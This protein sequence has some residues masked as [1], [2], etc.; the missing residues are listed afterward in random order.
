[1]KTRQQC[2][3]ILATSALLSGCLG[4]HIGLGSG[5]LYGGV[6]ANT[7]IDPDDFRQEEQVRFMTVNPAVL[8]IP[9]GGQARLKV[10]VDSNHGARI[11]SKSSCAASSVVSTKSGPQELSIAVSALYAAGR[12]CKLYLEVRS[13]NGKGHD[14]VEIG[15]RTY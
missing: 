6:S 1:M 3:A 11:S 7:R 4:A 14:K 8:N 13:P 15:I 10:A 5:G 2:A 9:Q 12:S